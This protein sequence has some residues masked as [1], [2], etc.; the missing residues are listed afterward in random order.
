M[1]LLSD[2]GRRPTAVIAQSDLL[3]AGVIRAAEELGLEVP[4]DV[5]VVG[6]DGVRVDGLWPY[7]LTTL[8]QPAVDKGRAA[9]HAI[10]EMLEGRVPR[11]ASFTSEL[12]RTMSVYSACSARISVVRLLA[13]PS[14]SCACPAR[15]AP[16]A[17]SPAAMQIA[18]GS[19]YQL[20][21]ADTPSVKSDRFLA[22]AA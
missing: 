6:F 4:G 1:A 12:R 11:P 18:P 13:A 2:P 5:S 22:K 15:T 21:A 16:T 7:D 17:T 14:A 19:P 3:A 9:G 10:V 20:V 8:V